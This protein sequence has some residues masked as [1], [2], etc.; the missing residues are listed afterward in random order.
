MSETMAAHFRHDQLA[1][2]AHASGDLDGRDRDRAGALVAA[3]AACASLLR[4]LRALAAALAALRRAVPPKRTRD[5]RLTTAEAARLRRF[6]WSIRLRGIIRPVAAGMTAAGLAAILL[7]TVP[8][9]MPAAAPI[10]Q[11]ESYPLAV[12]PD[13]GGRPGTAGS[14]S[15]PAPA[16]TTILDLGEAPAILLGGGLGL[17]LLQW[18]TERAGRP[19]RRR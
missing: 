10:D 16:S 3:C 5:Y 1:I 12:P 2:A 15:Q 8:T 18:G 6:A 17:F 19:S 13:G 14:P 7:T 9:T 11:R 4:D